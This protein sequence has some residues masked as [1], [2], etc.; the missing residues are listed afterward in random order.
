MPIRKCYLIFCFRVNLLI[1]H[2]AQVQF[3][4][5]MTKCIAK[6]I[7]GGAKPNSMC[8]IS[9]NIEFRN[10]EVGNAFGFCPKIVKNDILLIFNLVVYIVLLLDSTLQTCIC[11]FFRALLL[12]LSQSVSYTYLMGAAQLLIYIDPCENQI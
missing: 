8:F 1:N 9:I 4:A 5:M 12:T 2:Q 10:R 11:S 7:D 3:R 6:H